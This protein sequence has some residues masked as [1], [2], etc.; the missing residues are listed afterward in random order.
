MFDTK[1]TLTITIASGETKSCVVRRPT[2]EEWATR[3]RQ[4]RIVRQSIGRGKTRTVPTNHDKPDLTLLA[5]IRQDK[6][7]V[8]LDAAEAGEVLTR[9]DYSTVTNVETEPGG[10]TFR[11]AVEDT[12]DPMETVHRL[13]MPTA[14]QRLDHSRRSMLLENDGRFSETRVMLEPSAALYDALLISAEGYVGGIVPINHKF[15]VIFE[16]I[17]VVEQL[18]R[19]YTR[20]EA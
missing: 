2:D 9:L 13:R 11:L 20:P 7:G 14:K 5:A 1:E 4:C 19:E 8:E 15:T 6:D 17:D 16:L 12:V 18:Q 3:S 10:F